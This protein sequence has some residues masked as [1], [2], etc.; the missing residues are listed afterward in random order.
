MQVSRRLGCYCYILMAFWKAMLRICSFH[1]KPG[2]I[3][4]R[5]GGR[6]CSEAPK[7][8]AACVLLFFKRGEFCKWW[9]SCQSST[10]QSN[11]GLQLLL[12]PLAQI[13]LYLPLKPTEE[14]KHIHF[15]KWKKGPL[16]VPQTSLVGP[17]QAFHF[18]VQK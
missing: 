3:V 7:K 18:E 12:R 11:V 8:R 15:S 1:R 5:R 13:K 2:H 4:G 9:A 16:P 14:I 17:W 10:K 6:L